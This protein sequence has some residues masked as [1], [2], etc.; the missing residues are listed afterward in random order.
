MQSNNYVC[1]G[2]L[3]F[4]DSNIDFL[5]VINQYKELII[6]ENLKRLLTLGT[7][8]IYGKYDESTNIICNCKSVCYF[9]NT[10]Y[11]LLECGEITCISSIPFYTIKGQTLNEFSVLN[12][13]QNI[14]ISKDNY[15]KFIVI[16]SLGEVYYKNANLWEI[17]ELEKFG[18][19]PT[20]YII[21]NP[22]YLTFFYKNGE[23]C[24]FE[25]EMFYYDYILIQKSFECSKFLQNFQDNIKSIYKSAEIMLI[26]LNSG[27]VKS[28]HLKSLNSIG[29][30]HY[31][32]GAISNLH[33]LIEK[34]ECEL[35]FEILC[36]L[37][38]K[39]IKHTNNYTLLLIKKIIYCIEGS[40]IHTIYKKQ[41]KE[42]KYDEF[43]YSKFR[44]NSDVDAYL[45]NCTEYY[46]ACV[47]KQNHI[48]MD[49]IKDLPYKKL[50]ASKHIITVLLE[51]NRIICYDIVDNLIKDSHFTQQT[52]KI[53]SEYLSAG[54][55]TLTN[56]VYMYSD[57][58]GSYI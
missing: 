58:G 30:T 51:D 29:L 31:N 10:I 15:M 28:S 26:I 12:P 11:V 46:F 5:A 44:K 45:L 6:C 18:G 50:Y 38:V 55:H 3:F 42:Y 14:I 25:Y 16:T 23:I 8:K 35:N 32:L 17:N 47:I 52:Y 33:S 36:N 39:L 24:I 7:Y 57:V 27:S 2:M 56:K 40:S 54:A 1:V 34:T 20:H 37:P 19:P 21:N 13:I 9:R 4:I 43:Q 49:I 22:D 48:F 41:Y 53:N